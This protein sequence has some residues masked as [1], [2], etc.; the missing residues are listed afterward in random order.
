MRNLVSRTLSITH[1][2]EPRGARHHDF[3]A[4][5]IGTFANADYLSSRFPES[6]VKAAPQAG[7]FFPG[8]PLSPPFGAGLPLDYD[9]WAAG[10]PC[11][12][13]DSLLPRVTL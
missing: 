7:Y 4:G 11:E 12:R 3:Q 5:G 6:T 8:D 9:D 10:P 2:K 1:S 13:R